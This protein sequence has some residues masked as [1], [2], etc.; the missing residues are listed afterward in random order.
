MKLAVLTALMAIALPAP[1]FAAD[2]ILLGSSRGSKFYI[3]RQSIRTMPNGHKRV[4]SRYEY[5]SPNNLEFTSSKNY[6]EFDCIQDRRLELSSTF[7]KDEDVKITV[8]SIEKWD[9]ITPETVGES[10]FNYVCHGKH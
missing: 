6:T 10:E 7:Y 5:N 2:W 9:F 4:W 1:A 3:D 8:D